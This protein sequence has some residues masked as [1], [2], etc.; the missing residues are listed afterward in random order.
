MPH[1]NT[2]RAEL[3]DDIDDAAGLGAKEMKM[4][5][6]TYR[7]NDPVAVK[8]VGVA[9]AAVTNYLDKFSAQNGLLGLMMGA[10]ERAGV[11]PEQTLEIAKG[12]G[13]L[14]ASA[15]RAPAKKLSK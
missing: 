4:F 5:L 14:P 10:A 1:M 12:A 3:H 15:K 9:A 8:R 2:K 13:L 7:G 6:E 11:S